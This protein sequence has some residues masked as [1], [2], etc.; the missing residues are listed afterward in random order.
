MRSDGK[1]ILQCNQTTVQAK[2]SQVVLWYVMLALVLCIVSLHR[3]K[4]WAEVCAK[5]TALDSHCRIDI[6]GLAAAH[7]MFS[8]AA[9]QT[10]C[11]CLGEQ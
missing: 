4:G 2:V 8:G 9:Y 6:G 5:D 11:S 10:V 3:A 1:A 7:S